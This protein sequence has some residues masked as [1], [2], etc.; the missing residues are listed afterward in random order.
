MV[1]TVKDEV[2]IT[3][4]F[5]TAGSLQE[6]RSNRGIK[7]KEERMKKELTKIQG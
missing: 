6:V 3:T 7:W 4:V 2:F 1:N 5:L